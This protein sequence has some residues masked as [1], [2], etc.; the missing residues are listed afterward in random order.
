MAITFKY[1]YDVGDEL[2]YIEYDEVDIK[3]ELYDNRSVVLELNSNKP[4]DI[5]TDS[6]SI[7]DM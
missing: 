2:D 7:G 4:F 5:D 6:F 3:K 1:S